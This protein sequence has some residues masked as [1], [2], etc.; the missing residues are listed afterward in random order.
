MTEDVVEQ[1]S[2]A[3]V[4]GENQ[5]EWLRKAREQWML[6]VGIALGIVLVI[7]GVYWYMGMQKEKNLEAATHLSRIRSYFTQGDFEAAL[8]ADSI[9]PVGENKV[10]GLIE[11]S[12]SYEGTDAGAVAALMAGSAL[13]SLNRFSEAR[14]HF[15]RAAKN[16]A[17]VTE[18]GSMQGLAACLEAEGKLAEA[19][20]MYEKAAQRG[21]ETAFESQALFLAG[22][23]YEKS[24]NKEKAIEL[25][26]TV[27]KKFES[28]PTTPNARSGL[29]RLGMAID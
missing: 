8:T 23:C 17:T 29:A 9:P 19:A 15:E 20:A 2:A 25:Y 14:V 3:I 27:V 5:P 10:L 4:G 21:A 1:P 24:G 26:T 7:G 28:G 11:I 12:E 6:Y 13:A 22:L 16:G 18:V